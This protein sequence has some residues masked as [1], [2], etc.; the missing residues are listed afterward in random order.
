M[1]RKITA[2]KGT[3]RRHRR[4]QRRL[5]QNERTFIYATDAGRRIFREQSIYRAFNSSRRDC[6]C[7]PGALSYRRVRESASIQFLLAF[8]IRVLLYALR[9]L[10][11]LDDRS[12]RHRCRLVGG[13]AAPIGEHRCVVSCAGRSFYSNPPAAPSSL[14]VDGYS[15]WACAKSGFQ[16]RV[17]QFSL[18]LHSHDFLFC[19]LDHRVTFATAFFLAPG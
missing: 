4:R 12:P 16:A 14:P 3:N 17:P 2:R 18:V 5:L 11:F 19:F 6:R 15:P 1:V 10:L 7:E 9:R 13:C 8:C